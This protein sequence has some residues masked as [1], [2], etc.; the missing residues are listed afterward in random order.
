MEL[1]EPSPSVKV[2][3]SPN[4]TFVFT[5]QGAQWGG[6]GKELIED[7]PSFDDD[8]RLM[9]RILQNLPNPPFWD[10]RE[11]ILK[12]ASTSNLSKAEFSQPLCTAIQVALV[13]LL[14]S[15]NI[16]PAAVVGHSSGEI[17]AAYSAGAITQ[18]EA[19]LIAYHRGQAT[20]ASTRKGSMAAVGMGRTEVSLYLK[21]GVAIGCENSQS[22][23]TLSG[24]RKTLEEVLAEIQDDEPDVFARM[25]KV[26]MAYHSRR[27]TSKLL[28]ILD[29]LTYDQII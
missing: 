1:D 20:K 29:F 2:K 16:T 9:S 12:D 11:E 21:R 22:S 18:E 8:I 24:D 25:L 3:A 26:E 6:M 27:S 23:V 5:G 4:I 14:R 17:G 28:H 10:L 19:I 15:L 7:F 13:N